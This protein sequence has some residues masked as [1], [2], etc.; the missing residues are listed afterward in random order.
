MMLHSLWYSHSYKEA[1]GNASFRRRAIKGKFYYEGIFISTTIALYNHH[2][3]VELVNNN[4]TTTTSDF[5]S[6]KGNV[7]THV[8]KTEKGE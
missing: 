2:S 6:L 8:S 7:F 1:Q 5:I 3:S 4:K